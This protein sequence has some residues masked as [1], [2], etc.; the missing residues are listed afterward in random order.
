MAI[1]F[2]PIP[3]CKINTTSVCDEYEN[4]CEPY[5]SSLDEIIF[6]NKTQS[7]SISS[8]QHTYSVQ[9]NANI[10][11]CSIYLNKIIIS[12]HLVKWV[13]FFNESTN[14]LDDLLRRPDCCFICIFE[15]FSFCCAFPLLIAFKAI[16]GVI[17]ARLLLATNSET[18]RIKSLALFCCFHIDFWLLSLFLYCGNTISLRVKWQ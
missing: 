12:T 11:A 13:C 10:H 15:F 5:E 16:A 17:D 14:P 2:R 1:N 6:L 8:L 4:A 3:I 18:L 9:W 7:F